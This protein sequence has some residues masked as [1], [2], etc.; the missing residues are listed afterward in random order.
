MT[1]GL[2]A[3]GAAICIVGA[4]I[5][6]GLALRKAG[7][8]SVK[9]TVVKPNLFGRF[10]ILIALAETIAVYGLLMSFLLITKI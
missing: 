2:I 8:A 7:E 4:A 6:A 1:G 3:I 9:C 10:L 5:G